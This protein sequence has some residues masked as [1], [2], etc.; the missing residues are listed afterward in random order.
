[1]TLTVRVANDA[2]AGNQQHSSDDD[3]SA[4]GHKLVDPAQYHY[5]SAVVALLGSMTLRKVST[6][7]TLRK[8]STSVQVLY[9]GVS[10]FVADPCLE[11]HARGLF[12]SGFEVRA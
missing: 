12:V 6:P 1:V 4:A 11:C 9:L 3:L 8:V 2:D 7:V 10:V 5:S